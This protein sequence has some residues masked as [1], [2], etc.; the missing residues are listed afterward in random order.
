MNPYHPFRSQA[1]RDE[2]LAFYDRRA[3]RWPIPSTCL[4]LKTSYG[5]TFVRVSGPEGA[6]PLVLL[7]G[8]S[9]SGLMWETLIEPL[10]RRHRTYAV[11]NVNDVGR[12]VGTRPMRRARDF[13]D[14]LDELLTELAL[15]DGADLMGMSYGA[16]ITAHMALRHP[17]RVRKTVWLAPAG[18]VQRVSWW[19][20]VRA[21]LA[22]LHRSLHRN[23][24]DW[25]FADA[26]KTAAGRRIADELVEDTQM[27]MRCYERRPT[28]MPAAM[29][30]DELR[31]IRAPSLY[32]VGENETVCSARKALRRLRAVAPQ[33]RAEIVPGAGHDLP[34]VQAERVTETVLAFLAA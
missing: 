32:L 30:D 7:P 28:A 25:M 13:T 12:S 11:D 20:I 27:M 1:A 18:V 31:S 9:S 16:W 33:I 15:G 5:A 2:Y 8:M 19:W 23:F 6:P 21:L 14:W 22:G 26:V 3:E 10:S 24:T 17:E 34:I 29:S 4:T